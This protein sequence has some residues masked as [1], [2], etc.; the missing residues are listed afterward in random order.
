M[1]ERFEYGIALFN[2]REFYAC[3][4]VLEDLW[5]PLQGPERFFVQAIIH[6]AVAFYH[7]GRGNAI[8]AEK[9]LSRG[10]RKI[11]GYLPVYRGVDTGRLYWEAYAY[12]D[13]VQHG[14]LEEEFP[15]IE[16]LCE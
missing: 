15:T 5:R 12:R 2:R 14:C 13:A 3:H 10:L 16:L 9:Q 6:F 1:D 8:G 4:E 7:A 11:A